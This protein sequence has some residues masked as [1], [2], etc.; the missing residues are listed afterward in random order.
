MATSSILL[1]PG[2]AVLPDGSAGNLA[3][4]TGGY[5]PYAGM[6]MSGGLLPPYTPPAIVASPGPPMGSQTFQTLTMP[7][8]RM[9]SC[10]T[11]GSHTSCF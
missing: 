8:G 7:S 9:V 3:P 5:D 2:S 4:A 10:T 6:I 11:I 1:T